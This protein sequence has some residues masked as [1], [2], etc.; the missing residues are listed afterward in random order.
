M[1]SLVMLGW[2]FGIYDKDYL[3]HSLF[4]KLHLNKVGLQCYHGIQIIVITLLGSGY[5][6]NDLKVHN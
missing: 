4:E 6:H 1:A 5:V 2:F 3:R